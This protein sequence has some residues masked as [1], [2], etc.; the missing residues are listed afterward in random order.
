MIPD[1]ELPNIGRILSLIHI[2]RV[3]PG[4]DLPALCAEHAVGRLVNRL[5]DRSY[6]VG[7]YH[8]VFLFS[9]AV[10]A[11]EAWGASVAGQCWG[12]VVDSKAATKRFGAAGL[13]PR[14]G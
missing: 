14:A 5:V 12:G 8:R 2:Y 4:L 10:P 6:G 11:E 1:T 7:D 9:R 13:K 3:L